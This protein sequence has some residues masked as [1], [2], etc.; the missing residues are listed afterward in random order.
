[1]ADYNLPECLDPWREIIHPA[2]LILPRPS[3]A[4]YE[5]LKA[6][7][8]KNGM[9]VPLTTWI[10]SNGEHYLLDGI[11][12]LQVLVETNQQILKDE[13]G[14]WLVP[15]TPYSAADG[16][17]PYEIVT[18]LNLVRRHLTHEQKRDVVATMLKRRPELSDRAIAKMAQVDHHTVAHV[19]GAANGEL[20]HTTG[21]TAAEIADTVAVPAPALE[22]R[23]ATG[24]RARGRKPDSGRKATR[25]KTPKVTG[26]LSVTCDPAEITTALTLLPFVTAIEVVVDWHKKLNEDDQHIHRA[27]IARTI[28]RGSIQS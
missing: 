15:T 24:R 27:R 8:V 23:E 12:R 20:A 21:D 4:E 5:I 17:D 13:D 10:D 26:K 1:M 7:V 25:A 22:R 9:R 14:S 3:A 28:P 6:D 18:S 19:R 16:H 11:S 2:A